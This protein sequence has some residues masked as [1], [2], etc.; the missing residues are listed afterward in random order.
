VD[1]DALGNYI[2]VLSKVAHNKKLLKSPLDLSDVLLFK[3]EWLKAEK[4]EISDDEVSS[5]FKESIAK[6]VQERNR[7]MQPEGRSDV[8]DRLAAREA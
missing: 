3:D 4:K 2:K 7:R 5:L 6:A 1:E 8:K